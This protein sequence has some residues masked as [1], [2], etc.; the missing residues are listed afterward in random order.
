MIRRVIVI[1]LALAAACWTAA[2]IG[3]LINSLN[4][5]PMVLVLATMA[6]EWAALLLVVCAAVREVG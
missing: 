5:W 6:C 3:L 2:V 4:E 1:F